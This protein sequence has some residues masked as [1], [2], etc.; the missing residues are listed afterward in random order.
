MN[1]LKRAFILLAF[2]AAFAS[3]Y[4]TPQSNACTRYTDKCDYGFWGCLQHEGY[5]CERGCDDDD[6][7]EGP[8][9]I[10]GIN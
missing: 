1:K 7:I 4:L 6:Q 2:V 8:S 3:P 10:S 9:P 5:F